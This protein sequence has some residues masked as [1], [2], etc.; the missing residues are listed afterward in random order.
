MAELAKR[1]LDSTPQAV[2]I[3]NERGLEA[4]GASSDTLVSF[5]QQALGFG[6]HQLFDQMPRALD[7]VI[8]RRLWKDREKPFATFGEF[9]LAPPPSGLGVHNDRTLALLKAALDHKGKHIE[10]WSD[11]LIEVERATKV[12]QIEHV[13]PDN[14]FKVQHKKSIDG[15]LLTL[16]KERGSATTFKRIRG[17]KATVGEIA[18][19]RG[20]LPQRALTRYLKPGWRTA[21]EEE[22]RKFI[23]WLRQQIDLD[24]YLSRQ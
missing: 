10:E 11:V 5:V 22:R 16:R 14:K 13:S 17:G 15:T 20:L 7:Q 8:K 18:R 1:R 21:S 19:E 23:E 24:K 6:E 2:R 4:V 3:V 12:R 9:A